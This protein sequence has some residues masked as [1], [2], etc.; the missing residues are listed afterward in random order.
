M[1]SVF[2]RKRSN[3]IILRNF[4]TNKCFTECMLFQWLENSR[5]AERLTGRICSQF[6]IRQYF[7]NKLVLLRYTVPTY[8]NNVGYSERPKSKFVS[9]S[10]RAR[11]T[12]TGAI[13]IKSYQLPT[14]RLH[15]VIFINSK[16]RSFTSL[17]ALNEESW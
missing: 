13:K 16:S 10:D 15:F 9:I 6:R 7:G 12:V 4:K 14:I 3:H 17:S 5:M 1:P 8:D 2:N 11:V